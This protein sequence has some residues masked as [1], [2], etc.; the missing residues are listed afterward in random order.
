MGLS[1]AASWPST[2]KSARDD[3]TFGERLDCTPELAREP[4]YAQKDEVFE[5]FV[6]EDC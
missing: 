4:L 2:R 1:K 3:G 6:E 5:P